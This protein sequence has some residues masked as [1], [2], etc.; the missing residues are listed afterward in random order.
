MYEL[1]KQGAVH[2]VSGRVPMAAEYVQM[3]LHVFDNCFGHGQPHIV[4]HM[5][6]I[7]LLDSA[8]LELLLDIRDRCLHSGGAMQLASPNALC[9]DILRATGLLD[10]F[11]VFDDVSSAVGSFAQ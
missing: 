5:Q 11:A 1:S 6:G 3:A 9:R 7:P 2:I 8:G 4:L 10:H